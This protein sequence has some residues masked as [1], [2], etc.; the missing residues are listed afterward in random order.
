VT[1]SPDQ[2]KLATSCADG[3]LRVWSVTSGKLLFK[4]KSQDQV[5]YIR[6]SP[7]SKLL[8]SSAL[9]HTAK[10]WNYA[11][12]TLLKT[13]RHNDEVVAGVFSPDGKLILTCS[14]DQSAKIWNMATGILL[15]TLTGHKGMV[16]AG[17]FSENG[18]EVTTVGGPSVRTWDVQSGKMK[19][20]IKIDGLA[21]DFE[22]AASGKGMPVTANY[23]MQMMNLVSKQSPVTYVGIGEA[24][25]VVRTAEG[26]YRSTPNAAKRLHYVSD[27]GMVINFEQLDVKYNR[28]DK[29]LEAVG[30]SDT[31]QVRAMKRAYLKRLKRLSLDTTLFTKELDLP[32]AVLVNQA[33][34]EAAT[35]KTVPL[36]IQFAD[37]T[38]PLDRFNVWVNEVPV[39]GSKGVSVRSRNTRVIDTTIIVTLSA[40]ANSIEVSATNVNGL[41]SY[42]VPVSVTTPADTATKRKLHFIGIGLNHYENKEMNPLRWSIK[43]IRDLADTLKQKYPSMIVDTLMDEAATK[44]NILALRDKLLQLEEDDMLIISFSGH[45]LL[46]K[47]LDYY[48]STYDID[49]QQPGLNGLLYEQLETL[50]DNIRPRRKLLL[51]DACHSGELDKEEVE[52]IE[53]AGKLDSTNRSSIRVV[54]KKNIGMYNSFEL[55]KTLF[56]DVSRG[57]GAIVISAAGGMQYA[58]E[59][60]NLQNGVFTYSVLDALKVFKQLTVSQLKK[61]VSQKVLEL[62]KGLQQPTSRNETNNYDWVV[63]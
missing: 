31:V 30:S 33:D 21:Y 55:M 62:T 35:G 53:Q 5:E 34:V 11:A 6:F 29:I 4:T 22:L 57:T 60:E 45:G 23:E 52:K 59:N 9:D 41:E 39:Y 49:P 18:K 10:L 37:S 24:D 50:V 15:H 47:E 63:W 16:Q 42:R 32:Y 54:T 56:A 27:K 25:F 48:L 26:Y 28:P 38:E 7:D 58:L 3:F 14:S 61:Y 20:E 19:T 13:F 43:D 44:A 17:A 46:N 40:G 36:H 1:I 12:G 51:I 8:L 2:Q